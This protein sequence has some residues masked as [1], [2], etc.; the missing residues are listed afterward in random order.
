[1]L[2]IVEKV[3]AHI[4]RDGVVS[5]HDVKG[6]LT[7]TALSDEAGMCNVQMNV[8]RNNAEYTFNT[9]PKLNK[10]LYD[11]SG[12][13]RLKDPTKGFPSARPVGILKWSY[14]GT[15]ENMIPLK[16]NCW[17]EEESRGSMLVSIEYTMD[18]DI[19]LHNVTIKIPLGTSEAVRVH[20]ISGNYKQ[21]ASNGELLWT[22][23]MIDSSNSSGSLEFSV[24]QK[25][26]DAFF[27]IDVSF[28]STELFC[29][30]DVANVTSAT[31]EV[32]PIQYGL[33]KHMSTEEY[34]IA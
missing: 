9:H 28:S 31:D 21:N 13:L 16:I 5:D 15:N 12:L 6:S 20:S 11:K 17:P 34:I 24:P 1:M 4:S 22:L 2:A 29:H 30:I 25:N 32:T 8:G 23:D 14:S 33:T 26:S 19:T 10:A 27:P 3:T 18:L 7:L